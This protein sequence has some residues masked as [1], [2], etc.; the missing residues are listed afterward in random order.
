M[1]S[2]RSQT[3]SNT[4]STQVSFVIR[5]IRGFPLQ[6]LLSGY[7]T[8]P[9]PVRSISLSKAAA[10]VLAHLTMVTSHKTTQILNQQYR[11]KS[12]T[13]TMDIKGPTNR[14]KFQGFDIHSFLYDTVGW[15]FC[16]W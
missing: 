6:F 13:K 5:G 12:L 7:S 9:C 16:G 11:T 8:S 10:D 14:S 1:Q 3:A 2:R 15:L 4:C